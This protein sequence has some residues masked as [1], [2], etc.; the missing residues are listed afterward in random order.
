MARS[1]RRS[2]L[3]A[4]WPQLRRAVLRRDKGVCQIKGPRCTEQATE[5]DHKGAHDDHRLV[6]L[7]AVCKPCHASKTGRDARAARVSM[8]SRLRPPERHPSMRVDD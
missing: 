7:Q 3:P 5:V 6:M 1:W 2:P 8:P 4:N